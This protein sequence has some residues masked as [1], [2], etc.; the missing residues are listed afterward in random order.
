MAVATPRL[1]P[2]DVDP[3]LRVLIVDDSAVARAVMTR[4]V[5]ADARFAVKGS[6]ATAS[7]ALALLAQERVDLVLLDLQMPGIDGL[8]ALP[9]LIAAGRGAKI[10]VVSAQAGEGAESTLQ[11][12]ALGAADTLVKPAAG[13]RMAAFGD[14]LIG[15]LVRLGHSGLDVPP[16]PAAL[17]PIAPVS[18]AGRGRSDYDLVAIGAS[19]G[20][21]HA[22]SQ[23]LRALP[24]TF[25]VPILIT[26][27]LPA[28]FMPYFA[29]QI[30][31][32][33]GRP[34]DV[35]TDL[36]RVQPGRI[37]VAPGDAHLRCVALPD[38]AA[39]IRLSHAPAASGCLPSVDP[40]FASAAAVFGARML[41]IVLSGMGRDGAE[42][43][44]AVREA[45]GC[46]VVQDQTTSV[47]WGMPGA[48]A[49]IGAADAIL[50]PDAIGRLAIS[51]ARP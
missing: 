23:L 44:K 12:L 47:V 35:A 9:D 19:T 10:L 2:Q 15:K 26:Q 24:A 1:E 48:V 16:L 30:A 32:L 17:P 34:C 33:S 31:T 6:V 50:T 3:P 29:A 37:V 51:G 20:G 46:V 39:A 11:A 49:A 22:L 25:R 21:I 40:M 41:A 36:M 7:A 13:E 43:A 38:G 14:G 45:G 27:H 42:G 18:A 8:T 28:S 4:I 5:E